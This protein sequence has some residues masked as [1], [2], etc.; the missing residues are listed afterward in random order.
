MKENLNKQKEDVMKENLNKQKEG[1]VKENLKRSGRFTLIELL[2]VIAIITILAAMLLPMLNKARERANCSTCLNNLRQLNFAFTNY[3]SDNS[4]FFIPVN[5]LAANGWVPGEVEGV[6]TW[7]VGFYTGKYVTSNKIYI[8]PSVFKQS[9]AVYQ[10]YAADLINRP[11][12]VSRYQYVNY[13][14]NGNYIG[15]S[16]AVAGAKPYMPAKLNQIK[17]PTETILAAD[18]SGVTYKLLAPTP[19]ST[20]SNILDVHSKAANVLWAD[21]HVNTQYRS[22][23]DLCWGTSVSIARRYL[24]RN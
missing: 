11:Q 8:C 5:H 9:S 14:Y 20:Y 4:D 19:P 23:Y 16:I 18:S 22:M 24:D 12:I 17:K 15:S 1:A 13:G 3:T 7:G 21:G 2:V 6:W 10:G